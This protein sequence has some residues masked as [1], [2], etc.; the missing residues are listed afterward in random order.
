MNN[1]KMSFS[2]ITAFEQCPL[3]FKSQYISRIPTKT[4]PALLLG[5]TIH[6]TLEKFFDFSTEKR[7]LKLLKNLFRM[8]WK[9]ERNKLRE[10]GDFE[11]DKA[12]E[13]EHGKRG[14]M[15]LDNFYNSELMSEPIQREQF[16][17]A[18]LND[19]IQFLGRIDRL[20]KCIHNGKEGFKVID[21]KTGKLV[22][23]YV[24]FIQ[25]F[26]YAWLMNEQ[27]YKI[28]SSTFFYLEPNRIIEKSLNEQIFDQTRNTL[29][30]RCMP[31]YEA[32]EGDDFEP[33]KSAL[34]PYCDY[35][36][37]CPLQTGEIQI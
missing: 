5:Q 1:M 12:T 4:S 25:L 33:K 13:I 31:I 22:E 30:E 14:L 16:V 11:M 27:G 10:E 23:R 8:E 29:I 19:E 34:C 9:M 15:M 21:Y 3:K 7:D 28:Y 35:I 37:M 18:S 17:E 2:K 20:D 24:D 32:L 6:S 36:S 26:T